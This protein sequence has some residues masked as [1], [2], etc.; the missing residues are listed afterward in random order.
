MV[1][2]KAIKLIYWADSA[3]FGDSLSPYIIQKLTGA[4]IRH[5]IASLSWLNLVKT[6]LGHPK[7][8]IELSNYVL[9][10]E[11]NYIGVGS[12]LSY[13]NSRSRIWGSGFMNTSDK[14]Y[15]GKVYA[16]R[17][18]LSAKKIDI[19]N[20]YVLG[21]PALLLPLIYNAHITNSNTV[22]VIPHWKE[23]SFF[24]EKYSSRYHIID[25]CSSNVEQVIDDICSCKMIL[26]TSLHGIIVSHAYNI[27]AIW[28]KESNI[29]TDG[30]KFFD[31]FSSVKIQRYSGFNNYV[32]ILKSLDNVDDFFASHI[33]ISL[34]QTSL[35]K[36]QKELL[37]SVPFSLLE[38]WKQKECQL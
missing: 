4:K 13:G 34:P 36:I 17:G 31:Y 16:V 25:M 21:D 29:D 9:P 24:K 2:S 27:P 23:T 3:N 32:E 11:L 15:G 30:F 14:F 10:W 8:I 35:R 12:I 5:K 18:E 6:I 22:G 19:N 7:E 20:D 28:I 37:A 1:M 26:S 33:D 38:E